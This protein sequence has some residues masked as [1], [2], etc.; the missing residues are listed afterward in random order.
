MPTAPLPS[1]PPGFVWGVA[2]AAYQIE[3]AI[4]EDGRKPSIWDTFAATPGKVA[5]G[6]T[7][8]VACDHYHRWEA[9]L[10]LMQRLGVHAYR[11][12]VAWPRVIPDGTGA[13]NERGLDFYDRLVD[14]LLARGIEPFA[15][16]YHWDLPQPL[17]DAGGWPWRG[18]V[19]PFVAYA[20]AVT[21]RLGDRVSAYATLNEPWCSAVLGYD[22]GAHAPGLQDRALGLRAAHHLLLAHGEALPVMRA[23]AP[24]AKHGIVLN[25]NPG[26]PASDAPADAEAARR[27][28]GFFN[29]WYLD[30]LLLGRYPEDLWA[31]YGADVPDVADGDLAAIARPLDFLGVNY[32]NRTI[33]AADDG[34]R[35]V[36]PVDAPAD[37]EHTEMGWE[38]FPQGLTDLLVRIH[39]EYPLPPV[40][41]TENGAAYRDAVVDGRVDDP[42]RVRYLDRHLRALHAAM[43]QGVDV[44]GY[45]AWSLMDNFEWA[46]GYGKRF[47]LVHVDYATQ[48]RTPKTS[49]TWYASAIAAQSAAAQHA[50]APRDAVGSD[51]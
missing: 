19:E 45:F 30:P 7:G 50:P 38:V 9:D 11:F 33:L 32:Y 18:I 40:Y 25:L 13:V 1:F 49:A 21:R 29:R 16:L 15:T 12:S 36:R 51:A 37:A 4:A 17:Q 48:D 6:D 20:D 47:G 31:G 28:D 34:P 8:A 26:Y 42:E 41:L 24:R 35:G 2:T 27:F 3:G 39:R 5:H 46:H 14:G 44:R 43:A 22:F 23:N 10:D